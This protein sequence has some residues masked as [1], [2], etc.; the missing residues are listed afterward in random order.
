MEV[1]GSQGPLYHGSPRLL[2]L[3]HFPSLLT[4]LLVLRKVPDWKPLHFALGRALSVGDYV[5]GGNPFSQGNCSSC[6]PSCVAFTEL[7]AVHSCLS[8]T[9]GRGTRAKLHAV[10]SP[11]GLV[12][13][14]LPAAQGCL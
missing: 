2:P 11:H 3:P 13:T 4:I 1:E 10:P 12:Q 8:Y 14:Q 7:T 5:N 9:G 6:Q